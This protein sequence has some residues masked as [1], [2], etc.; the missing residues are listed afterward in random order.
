MTEKDKDEHLYSLFRCIEGHKSDEYMRKWLG[1]FMIV[2]R[3][4]ILAKAGLYLKLKKLKLDT[5]P[6][7]VK[8]RRCRDILTVFTLS[9]LISKHTLVH[10]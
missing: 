5:W 2:H 6:E 7:G 10:L 8:S 4:A 1:F 9:A 3:Q